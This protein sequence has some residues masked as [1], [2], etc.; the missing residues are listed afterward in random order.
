MTI[1]QN[2]TYIGM[3]IPIYF[4]MFKIRKEETACYE[5]VL[6]SRMFKI[7]KYNTIFMGAVY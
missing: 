2:M 3:Q 4:L 5:Y 6:E 1:I 7:E